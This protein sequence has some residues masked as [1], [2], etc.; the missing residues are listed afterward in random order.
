MDGIDSVCPPS[1]GDTWADEALASWPGKV[2]V[3][4]LEP[5]ALQRMTVEETRAYTREV[6]GRVAPGSRLIL[7]TG[8]ATSYG[9]PVE[10]LMAV[11]EVVEEIGRG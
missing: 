6:L 11:G 5:P 2:V 1:T 10:N 9:T 7:S 8:D 4:G 3:G